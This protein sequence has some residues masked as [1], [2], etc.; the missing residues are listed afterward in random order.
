MNKEAQWYIE[1][2]TEDLTEEEYQDY[3]SMIELEN[4]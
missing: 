1:T 2:F 4:T 3:L